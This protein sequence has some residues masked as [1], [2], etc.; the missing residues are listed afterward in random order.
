MDN[1]LASYRDQ[2]AMNP[3][4]TEALAKLEA[5][6]LQ[7]ED[8]EGL[9]ALT[10]EV[11]S[12]AEE[13]G[14]REAWLRLAT[15][16]E[17]HAN[18]VDSTETASRIHTVIGRVLGKNLSMAEDAMRFFQHAFQLDPSNIEALDAAREIYSAREDWDLVAHLYTLQADAATAPEVK[19]DIYWKL[20][21]L[22]QGRMQSAAQAFKWATAALELAP[23][24]ARAGDFAHLLDES[25][26]NRQA[27]FDAL[28]EEIRSIRDP[29]QRSALMIEQANLWFDESP[30]DLWVE[31]LLRNVLKRDPR[32]E[33]AKN[34]LDEY[35]E[36]NGRWEELVR[37]L[38][39]RVQKTPRKSDRLALFQRLAEIAQFNL[40]DQGSA[41]DWHREVLKLSPSE[42]GSLKFC[43]DFYSDQEDWRALVGVY[44]AALRSRKRGRND[45]A[46][47]VQIAML[48]WKKLD[49]FK[50]AESYFKRIKLNEP[51]N[52]L[53]L[54]F[55][56]EH[57]DR[58][59]DWK[60][61]LGVLQTRQGNEEDTG[62]KFDIGLEM[63]AVAETKL[64]NLEKAIDIWKSLVRLAPERPEARKAL[65]R[66]YFEGRKWNALLEFLKDDLKTSDHPVEHR[67][68][69]HRQ[70]IEIYRDHLNLP[71]MVINAYNKI[72]EFDPGNEE[73]LSALESKYREETRWNDLIGILIRRAEL[74][75]QAEDTDARV[76]LLRGVAGIWLEK[77]SNPSKAVA[78]LEAILDVR[79]NDAGAIES[80]I[81][82]FEHR[83]DWPA[84]FE[85]YG[86]QLELLAGEERTERLRQMARIAS[87]RLEDAE[88][89]LGLWRQVLDVSPDDEGAWQAIENL[90][91]KNAR[92]EDLA[93]L[94]HQRA[95]RAD[96][97]DQTLWLKKL[98]DIFADKLEDAVR[99]AAVWREVLSIDPEDQL[100]RPRGPLRRP[101]R[102]GRA[103]S[104]IWGRRRE[105]AGAGGPNRSLSPDGG[106]LS[107]EAP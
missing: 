47:L 9:V 75:E 42:S 69:I 23:D 38:V 43:V 18:A 25:A 102:L 33:T 30:S 92:W 87:D 40:E 64:K 39:D 2:L 101:Q 83:K 3:D 74:A 105:A 66:L 84:L 89:A 71:V 20:A 35:Y 44:D 96:G 17:E 49:D 98:G 31:E 37:Y 6:L 58:L 107:G 36:T 5:A 52:P 46:M 59:S 91:Q 97:A 81:G 29:R 55:Y 19:G 106:R 77:F 62:A 12:R 100:D 86:R 45:S 54:Q 50:G 104:P 1:E 28:M 65:R 95:D 60:R 56:T 14:A 24:D 15:G 67:V 4:D 80:L 82:I 63:A 27:R 94:Y 16:L 73:A 99:A 57:Y 88:G 22:A 70:M 10:G 26:R 61:L 21:A 11:A 79:P 34:L 41:V 32:N 72:L 51:R 93:E 13:S 76:E 68:E 85:V 48:L 90:N 78:Y 8:W 103:H 7:D 53:M